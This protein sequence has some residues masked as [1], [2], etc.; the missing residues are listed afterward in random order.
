MIKPT[1]LATDS[2]KCFAA[3]LSALFLVALGAKLWVVQLYG[4]PLPLWDQ[5]YEAGGF[6]RP[7][8][9]GHLTWKDFFSAYC[10]HRMLFIRLLDLSVIGLNGRWEPMLQMTVNAFICATYACGLAFCLW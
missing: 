7:W 2:F 1:N 10:E 6:F 8:L 9:E 5:W 4:S 3:W